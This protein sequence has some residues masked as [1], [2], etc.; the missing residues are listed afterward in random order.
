MSKQNFFNHYNMR[1]LKIQPA[2]NAV[3]KMLPE[4]NKL[5]SKIYLPVKLIVRLYKICVELVMKI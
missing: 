5:K 1:L 2:T 4:G 3:L